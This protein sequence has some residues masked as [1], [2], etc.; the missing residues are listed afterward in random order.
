MG[1]ASRKLDKLFEDGHLARFLGHDSHRYL[2]I[3]VAWHRPLRQELDYL[4]IS[5][6]L[7]VLWVDPF[8]QILYFCIHIL[9]EAEQ[10]TLAHLVH[11]GDEQ[12]ELVLV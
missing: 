10:A 3:R 11:V 1:I 2:V 12:L 9:L 6:P 8:Q 5:D 7:V 4:R